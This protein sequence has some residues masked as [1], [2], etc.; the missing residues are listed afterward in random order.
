[1]DRFPVFAQLSRDSSVSLQES[2][3]TLSP[4]SHIR[5]PLKHLFVAIVLFLRLKSNLCVKIYISYIKD[6]PTSIIPLQK[7][8]R[9]FNAMFL[10]QINLSAEQPIPPNRKEAI[11]T[12]MG[13]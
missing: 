6:D 3:L 13:L 7:C 5:F 1:M 2:L 4:N 11:F 9:I 8:T 12:S 10:T